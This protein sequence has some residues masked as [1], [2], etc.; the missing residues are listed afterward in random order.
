MRMSYLGCIWGFDLDARVLECKVPER[1]H[2]VR[3]SDL[4]FDVETEGG[5]IQVPG[6]ADSVTWLEST[7]K[8]C[9]VKPTSHKPSAIVKGKLIRCRSVEEAEF[10]DYL[11]RWVAANEKGIDRPNGAR[12]T[13]ID[14]RPG[15]SHSEL[16]LF[17]LLLERGHHPSKSSGRIGWMRISDTEVTTWLVLRCPSLHTTS[18]VLAIDLF[19]LSL[20]YEGSNRKYDSRYQKTSS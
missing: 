18:P 8:A 12:S 4:I 19:P 3:L 11:V 16:L 9:W 20:F 6:G 1:S 14:G 7:V 10:L 17:T 13:A 5:V 15:K 2:S